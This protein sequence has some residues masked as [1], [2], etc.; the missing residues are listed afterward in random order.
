MKYLVLD[1]GG[2]AIKYALMTKE[3]EFVEKG[4]IKTPTESIEN[5]V[6]VVGNI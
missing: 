1:I 5:F 2:S 6:S 4:N 3:L